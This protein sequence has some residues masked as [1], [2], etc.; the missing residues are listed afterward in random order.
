MCV[1]VCVCV[2]LCVCVCGLH[3]RVIRSVY[4]WI[5]SGPLHVKSMI[6]HCQI[7]YSNSVF[8]L[9]ILTV[10]SPVYSWYPQEEQKDASLLSL[11]HYSHSA[12]AVSC[13][14]GLISVLMQGI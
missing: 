3:T 10:D 2:C 11:L 7:H 9:V 6:S 12:T 4:W 8:S 14:R 13:V 1:C 5:S